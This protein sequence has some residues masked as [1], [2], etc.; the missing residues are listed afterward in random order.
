M[1]NR[2]PV[3][4]QTVQAVFNSLVKSS[5]PEKAEKLLWDMA[6]QDSSPSSLSTNVYQTVIDAYAKSKKTDKAALL[7]RRLEE[8]AAPAPDASC[9]NTMIDSCAKM[10]D[11][12]GAE[13]WMQRLMS[14]SMEPNV[15]SFSSVIDAC[16]K[17]GD[18]AKAEKWMSKMGAIG[19]E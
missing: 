4:P 12:K 11:V 15:V 3:A 13:H 19:I 1:T 16:A 6:F 5:D 18:V 17:A 10:A 7:L 2:M 8:L 14:S 9:Y